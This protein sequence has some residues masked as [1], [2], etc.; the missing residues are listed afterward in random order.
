[1]SSSFLD[2]LTGRLT[3]ERRLLD[4]YNL[5]F[6]DIVAVD[7]EVH[8]EPPYGDVYE[9]HVKLGVRNVLSRHSRNKD[10]IAYA[11]QH[12]RRLIAE[13]V[14]KDAKEVANKLA[15]QLYSERAN[16]SPEVNKL[17]M[18]LFKSME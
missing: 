17:L 18:E 9:V 6:N 5:N 16:M 4:Q 15:H 1:M 7:K 14:Y 13:L 3:G 11:Q 10:E 8:Y 12:S 2:S